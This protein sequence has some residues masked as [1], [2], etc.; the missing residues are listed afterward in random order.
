MVSTAIAV[1]LITIGVFK[2]FSTCHNVRQEPHFQFT[3]LLMALGT[4]VFT[5]GGHSAFPTIQHDMKKPAEFTKS[6]IMAFASKFITFLNIN[7]KK[8]FY[9]FKFFSYLRFLHSSYSPFLP[10]LWRFTQRFHHSLHPNVLDPTS[11]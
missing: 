1:V 9:I 2:D 6:S 8:Y 7:F 11:R 10:C 5:F 3:N 4:I